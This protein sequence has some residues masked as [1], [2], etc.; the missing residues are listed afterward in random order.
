METFILTL[1]ILTL[2]FLARNVN[3]KKHVTRIN[4]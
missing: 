4:L 1:A 3:F 2:A